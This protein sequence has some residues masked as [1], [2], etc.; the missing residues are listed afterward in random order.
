[1]SW[2]SPWVSVVLV[3][4]GE[5]RKKKS[6]LLLL[7]PRKKYPDD[8]TFDRVFKEVQVCVYVCARVCTHAYVWMCVHVRYVEQNCLIVSYQTSVCDQNLKLENHNKRQS[9]CKKMGQEFSSE[10]F[11]LAFNISIQGFS[12]FKKL[13]LTVLP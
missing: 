11:D 9:K 13:H 1:M 7:F 5:K 12:C 6:L 10:N 4:P 3:L 2:L 8:Q